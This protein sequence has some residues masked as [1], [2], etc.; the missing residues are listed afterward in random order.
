MNVFAIGDLHL[1]G[2]ADKSMDLFGPH[3]EG[4]WDKIR[5]D[6]RSRVTPEDIVLIPGDISWAMHLED[7]V[8][9]L[10]SIGEMPGRKILLRGNHDYWW[11]SLS[12]VRAALPP[13]MYVLQNDAL[14]LEGIAFCG[15]RGWTWPQNAA[16][17]EDKRIYDREL[18]RL[19]LSLEWARR[20]QPEGPLMVLTHYPPLGEG[21]MDT[22]VS[23]LLAEFRADHVVYGHLHGASIRGAFSGMHRGTDYHFVSCDGLDFKLYRLPPLVGTAEGEVENASPIVP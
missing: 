18:I 3:W 1:P 12:R 8:P 5:A 23:D 11:G 2:G 14:M 10:Q 16:E 20:L 17:G 22:P 6:W 7:A 4:H 21:G 19:R 15:S 9:D 13:G